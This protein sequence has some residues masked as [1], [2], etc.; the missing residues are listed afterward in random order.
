MTPERE[1]QLLAEIAL[2]RA[3]NQLLREKVSEILRRLYDKKSE[4]LDAAQLELLLDPDAAKKATAADPADQGPA[5]ETP[6][7]KKRTTRKPR[8]ISH[9]PVRETH[10]VPDEVKANP[11]AFRQIDC[12]STDRFD[13]QRAVIFIE[14][15]IRPVYVARDNPDAAPIKSC[16]PPS[17]GLGATPRLV[18]YVLAAK[19]CHHRPFYRTQGILLRRHRVEFARNTFCHWA[20]TVADTI[21]PLYKLIHQSLLQTGNLQADET[22]IKYLNPGK[23]KTSTGYLWVI[24]APRN[25]IKGDILYQW[26][27]SRKAACLDDLIENYRGFLQTDAYVGYDSW[28]ADKSGIT[29]V[30]CWAH[31]RRKFHEAF[32]IGQTLAAGPLATIQQLY[33]IETVLRQANADAAERERMRREK[34]ASLLQ[35]LKTQLVTLRQ[36]PQVLP[37]GKLGR[38]I[39]YTLAIWARLNTYVDHGCLEIDNN[40]IEN[41]IR[42]TAIGK[43]NWLFMGAE[44][45]GQRGAI[46]YT[47]V[48]CARRHGHDP[49]AYLANILERLPAM[50]NQDDLT[51]LLP[52]NWQPSATTPA[53][54]VEAMI[55]P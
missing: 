53:L 30:A 28:T 47:L 21:E 22:P 51:V 44:T 24:H 29:L 16:A 39:D 35:I 12:V 6:V 8:D 10:L 19:Y 38:A 37:K 43:K 14:R 18:A 32:Q 52:S 4:T 48:E 17:L 49:E 5:A 31:A 45:T 20:A 34:A 55:T 15:V 13:Y 23:G 1:Q 3:E 25:G 2:L 26:H 9:L 41:G 33:Q 54:E 40:W 11:N 36:H 46:I 50:T 27:S 7:A 42:P